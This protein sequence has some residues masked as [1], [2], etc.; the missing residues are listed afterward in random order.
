MVNGQVAAV[1]Y[2]GRSCYLLSVDN[3]H[4]QHGCELELGPVSVRR[5]QVLWQLFL[6]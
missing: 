1:P 4:A 3:K 2:V 5:R 6:G